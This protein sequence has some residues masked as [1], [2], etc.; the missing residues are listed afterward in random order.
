[1]E[2][3]NGIFNKDL[4]KQYSV[5]IFLEVL[6]VQLDHHLVMRFKYQDWA[7]KAATSLKY[8]NKIIN[9]ENNKL[10][11]NYLDKLFLKVLISKPQNSPIFLSYQKCIS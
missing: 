3:Y 6:R 8:K 5:T 10:I 7:E 11:L 1:M 4:S 2:K 9:L